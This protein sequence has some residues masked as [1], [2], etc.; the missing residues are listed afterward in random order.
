MRNS[1]GVTEM[2]GAPLSNRERKV[3]VW[4][5]KTGYRYVDISV[6]TGRPMGT[7]KTAM[8]RLRA[9]GVVA[10]RYSVADWSLLDA[11]Q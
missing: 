8:G 10:R 1:A 11:A 7:V 4:M 2:R 6:A 5:A 9:D 3:I